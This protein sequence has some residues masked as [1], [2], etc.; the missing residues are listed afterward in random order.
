MKKKEYKP[1]LVFYIKDFGMLRAE[2]K[3][4]IRKFAKNNNYEVLVIGG[5]NIGNDR[6]EIISVDRAVVVEDVTRFFEK[7]V[8][9][10]GEDDGSLDDGKQNNGLDE[11]LLFGGK[12]KNKKNK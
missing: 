11:V 4:E 1:I 8:C 12:N 3:E 10:V 7:K 5:D 9:G 2:Q 6:V